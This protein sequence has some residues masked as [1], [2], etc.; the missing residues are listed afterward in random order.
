MT[1]DIFDERGDNDGRRGDAAAEALRDALRDAAPVPPVD[2]VDWSA[3]HARINAAAAPLLKSTRPM[4]EPS[5]AGRAHTL[6]Q[7]LAVW[8]P[9]GIPLAAAAAVVLMFGAGALGSQQAGVADADVAFVTVE[10][11]L[12]NGLSGGVRPLLAGLDSD[13]FIDVALFYDGEDW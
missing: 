3:L 7:P 10:E 2:A 11:A 6:W 12:V 8:S 5:A 1:R 13:A 4:A 9:L